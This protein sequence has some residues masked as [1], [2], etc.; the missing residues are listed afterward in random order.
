MIR[1]QNVFLTNFHTIPVFGI[2][3]SALQHIIK[4]DKNEGTSSHM[5]LRQYITQQPSING[6]ETINRASDLVKS[7]SSPTPS[8]SSMHAPLSMTSSLSYATV[9]LIPPEMVLEAFD[10]PRGGDAP[11]T[12]TNFQSYASIHAN[13]GNPQGDEQA[14]PGGNAPPPRPPKRNVQMVYDLTGDFPNLP[15]RHNQNARHQSQPQDNQ[16]STI[17]ASNA[18]PSAA[19]AVTVDALAKF[20]EDMKREFMTMIQTEVK[21]QIET[22]MK[23]LQADVQTLSAKFDGVQEGIKES[24]GETVR[25][26]VLHGMHTQPTQRLHTQQ[27]NHETAQTENTQDGACPMQTGTGL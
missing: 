10:P 3:P 27:S 12:S 15:R 8:T 7:L 22:Q 11:R 23:A 19:P 9:D 18:N 16:P 13:L 20:K 24:I 21:T 1:M 2:L 5:S 6:I 25:L 14:I 4:L 17:T 26:A